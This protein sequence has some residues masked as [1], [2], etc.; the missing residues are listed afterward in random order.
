MP[1]ASQFPSILPGIQ[2]FHQEGPYQHFT[3]GLKLVGSYLYTPHGVVL[4]AWYVSG[5]VMPSSPTAHTGA[6]LPVQCW[7][8]LPQ[9]CG[10]QSTL[11]ATCRPTCWAMCRSGGWLSLPLDGMARRHRVRNHRGG[12]DADMLTET[13]AAQSVTYVCTHAQNADGAHREPTSPPGSSH[14]PSL[15]FASAHHLP[16]LPSVLMVVLPFHRLS[17]TSGGPQRISAGGSGG[18]SGNEGASEGTTDTGGQPT[19]SQAMWSYPGPDSFKLRGHNYL[20]D[21]K[22]V[23]HR[24]QLQIW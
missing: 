21:K 10:T 13:D 16:M 2:K 5:A 14:T 7:A 19:L 9:R 15:P 4:H 11:S 6:H 8:P 24:H 22:K 23:S 20:R 12:S 17:Q 1:F 3:L 18:A